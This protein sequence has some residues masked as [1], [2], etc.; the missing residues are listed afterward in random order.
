MILGLATVTSPV[1]RR[2]GSA[3]SGGEHDNQIQ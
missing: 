2:Q 1:W 3:G